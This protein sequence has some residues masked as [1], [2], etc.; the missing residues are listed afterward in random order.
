MVL[1]LIWHSSSRCWYSWCI[2][3]VSVFVCFASGYYYHHHHYNFMKQPVTCCTID[4]RVLSSTCLLAPLYE[5]WLWGP[6]RDLCKGCRR[7]LSSLYAFMAR[8]YEK[9]CVI[10]LLVLLL[11]LLQVLIISRSSTFLAVIPQTFVSTLSRFRLGIN[12]WQREAPRNIPENPTW[13]SEQ[14]VWHLR[15][16]I[17]MDFQ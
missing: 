17:T 3:I 8:W 11:L 7:G 12:P 6:P 10:L 9:D 15:Q 14:H 2:C 16:S 13:T 4:V 1:S 5:G